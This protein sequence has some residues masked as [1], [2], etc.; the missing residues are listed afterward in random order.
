MDPNIK[1]AYAQLYSLTLEHEFTTTSSSALTIPGRMVCISMTS[2]TLTSPALV[3]LWAT[4][5]RAS[6]AL[7]TTQYSNINWRGS[8]GISHYNA[9]VARIQMNNWAKSGLTLNANYTYGHTQ[10]ELSDT[11]SSSANE[12][13]LGYLGA[14]NPRVDYG[15]SYL[16]IRHRFTMSAIW[17]I[18]F[19]K[20]THGFVKQV[21]DGWTIAPLLLFETG[22]PFSV[23]DCTN[24]ATDCMYA[25]NASGGMKQ[26]APEV[27]TDG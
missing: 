9:L 19:A 14:F 1:Q 7:R 21:A 16:D 27:D 8:N 11:F 12:F 25:V 4:Q 23:Y 13:N 5:S 26:G 2:R 15:N 17:E 20:T 6:A 24:A 10:D 18:P 3:H 22:T